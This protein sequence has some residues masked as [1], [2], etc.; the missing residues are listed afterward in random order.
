MPRVLGTIS[1]ILHVPCTLPKQGRRGLGLLSAHPA[2]TGLPQS[3]HIPF[4]LALPHRGH[5]AL[6][7]LRHSSAPC[8]QEPSR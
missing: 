1:A 6:T 5:V 8:L 2:G 3:L 4:P 7:Q